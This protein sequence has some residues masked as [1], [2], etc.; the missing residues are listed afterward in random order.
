MGRKRVTRI[1]P[2]G[3]Q[4]EVSWDGDDVATNVSGVHFVGGSY[5]RAFQIAPVGAHD[6]AA[7][8][9]LDATLV[10]RVRVKGD[11]IR[12]S[13]ARDGSSTI[14]SLIGKYHELMTVFSGPAPEVGVITELF[15]VLDVKDHKDGMRVIPQGATGLT[16]S[17][18]H[19][20]IQNNDSTSVD[21]PAPAFARDLIP[22]KAGRKTKHGEVWRTQLPGRSGNKA[23]DYSY[24]VGTP[25]GV[26]EVMFADE[27]AISE[28]Q[29]LT[30]I[31]TL[32]IRWS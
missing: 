29:A 28:E 2:S 13:A 22:R 30:V 6:F 19:V 15:A 31:D 25:T 11:E 14:A 16:V 23:H 10:S 17:G 5:G 4:L 26:A 20:F 12:I 27:S 7:E 9:L 21:A 18:E 24:V 8:N 1:G 32:D 3:A